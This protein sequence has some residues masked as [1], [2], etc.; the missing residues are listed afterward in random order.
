M[1]FGNGYV[2]Y[3]KNVKSKTLYELTYN[4]KISTGGQSVQWDFA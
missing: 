1:P 2:Y 3:K 4:N